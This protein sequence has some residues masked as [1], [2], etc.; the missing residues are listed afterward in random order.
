MFCSKKYTFIIMIAVEEGVNFGDHGDCNKKE[1]LA[2]INKPNDFIFAMVQ[3]LDGD[4]CQSP[5]RRS[6]FQRTRFWCNE[7]EQRVQRT[8]RKRNHCE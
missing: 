6:R 7:C 8:I 1:I 2:S 3:F 5:Y 4:G